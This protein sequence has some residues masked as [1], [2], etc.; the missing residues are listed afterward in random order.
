MKQLVAYRTDYQDPLFKILHLVRS[1]AFPINAVDAEERLGKTDGAE[2]A[3]GPYCLHDLLPL[4]RTEVC[5]HIQLLRA[6]PFIP[7][8]NGTGIRTGIPV[9]REP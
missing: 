4:F 7:S 3:T 6:S 5:S 1:R 9:N 8:A 2:F